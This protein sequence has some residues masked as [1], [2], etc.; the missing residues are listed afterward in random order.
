[1]TDEELIRR[2]LDAAA[3]ADP[4]DVPIGAVVFG[5]DGAEL[6]DLWALGGGLE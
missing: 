5:A 2:A 6:G 1:M 3:A 4:R